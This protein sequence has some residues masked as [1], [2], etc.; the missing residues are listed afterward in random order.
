MNGKGV[1]LF[2]VTAPTLG[3]RGRR[4]SGWVHN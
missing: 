1:D 4:T 3:Y 2:E